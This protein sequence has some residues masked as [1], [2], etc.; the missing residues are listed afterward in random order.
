MKKNYIY[1]E[2]R[3]GV[4]PGI[5]WKHVELNKKMLRRLYNLDRL[6]EWIKEKILIF[7]KHVSFFYIH[8]FSIGKSEFSNIQY[9]IYKGVLKHYCNKFN[10]NK[11]TKSKLLSLSKNNETILAINLLKGIIAEQKNT[12]KI[13]VKVKNIYNIKKLRKSRI[14]RRHTNFMN[15]Y[16]KSKKL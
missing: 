8:E 6:E 7:E 3:T 10:I 2:F 9:D 13:N 4:S 15:N 16:R 12:N 1:Y 11:E 14:P 5:Y